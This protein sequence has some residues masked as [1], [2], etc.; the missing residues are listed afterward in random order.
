VT[1]SGRR[2]ATIDRVDQVK[3]P[4]RILR[5]CAASSSRLHPIT[6]RRVPAAE[7]RGPL[8]PG[9][10]CGAPGDRGNK[11]AP[12]AA[13]SPV[14]VRFLLWYAWSMTLASARYRSLGRDLV[15]E[16]ERKARLSPQVNVA[17]APSSSTARQRF[18]S[19][20]STKLRRGAWA[21]GRGLVEK[22]VRLL[23]YPVRRARRR[24]PGGS[25]SPGAAALKCAL[26]YAQRHASP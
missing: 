22:Y 19:S 3:T 12:R 18:S 21:G 1:A 24:S 6:S 4:L 20:S 16:L 5:D 8:R 11:A 25:R 7:D 17:F 13:R 2:I 10:M 9:S 23:E 14:A 26:R 15:E